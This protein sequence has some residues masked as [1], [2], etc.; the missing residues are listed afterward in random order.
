MDFR[1]IE[2]KDPSLQNDWQQVYKMTIP[3]QI[4]LDY[5]TSSQYMQT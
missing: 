3:C 5:N 4:E 2:E 1:E